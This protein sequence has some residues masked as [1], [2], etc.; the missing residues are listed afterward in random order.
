MLLATS[1]AI[2]GPALLLFT[3]CTYTT[4]TTKAKDRL[5]IA[6]N[7]L[8]PFLIGIHVSSTFANLSMRA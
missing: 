1:I 7:S 8:D 5:V 2:V 6:H 4:S 3:S